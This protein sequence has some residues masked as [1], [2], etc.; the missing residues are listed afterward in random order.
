MSC[1][2]SRPTADHIRHAGGLLTSFSRRPAYGA[3][4]SVETVVRR[5]WQ[6][7]RLVPRLSVI[8][9]VIAAVELIGLAIYSFL[10]P[11]T[12]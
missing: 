3:R 6:S 12:G 5:M 7:H 11:V 1:A 4:V 10:L 8:V 2:R 9:M